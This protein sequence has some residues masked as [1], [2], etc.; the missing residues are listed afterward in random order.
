M[1][2]I[3]IDSHLMGAAQFMN[4]C[5]RIMFCAKVEEITFIFQ[6]RDTQSRLALGANAC[7]A[8]LNLETAIYVCA[9]VCV[10]GICA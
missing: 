7:R 9:C 4:A 3:K 10:Y 1:V 2:Y 6:I 8:I 5:K